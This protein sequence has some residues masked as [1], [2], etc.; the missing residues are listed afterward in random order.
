MRILLAVDGSPYTQKMLDYLATHAEWLGDTHSYVALTVQP[1]LPPRAAK[2]LG[3]ELVNDYHVEE[4]QKVL[5]PVHQFV[6]THKLNAQ[7]ESKVGHIAETIAAMADNGG[8]D[9]LIMGTR[10]H[11]ALAKLVMG[12]V[13]TQV[14][15]QSK[16]PVLL[17]R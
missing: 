2:A 10:G 7:C 6:E 16:I 8:Y 14:L 15:A 3:K 4:A 17:I 11:G 13:A 12:S 9:L 5:A 1:P